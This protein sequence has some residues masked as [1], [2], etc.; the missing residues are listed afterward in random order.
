MSV[1]NIIRELNGDHKLR[2]SQQ[3]S[4]VTVRMP[5][6]LH[7]RIVS[8]AFANKTS[9]NKLSCAAIMAACDELESGRNEHGGAESA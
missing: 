3:H 4:I 2:R 6:E 9:I 5:S 1:I 8:L 7:E